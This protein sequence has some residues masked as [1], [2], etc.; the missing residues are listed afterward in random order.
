MSIEEQIA[1]LIQTHLQT[2]HEDDGGAVAR[3]AAAVAGLL[4]WQP[5]DAAPQDGTHFLAQAISAKAEFVI[6]AWRQGDAYRTAL[7][8]IG[9]THSVV[10]TQWAPLVRPAA[11]P[12]PVQ[13]ASASVNDR[14]SGALDPLKEKIS[15]A[16]ENVVTSNRNLLREHVGT[17]AIALLRDDDLVVK[18]AEHM[19]PALPFALRIVVKEDAF[20]AFLLKHRELLTAALQRA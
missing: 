12:A 19:Y 7:D 11:V 20:T 13:A 18:V 5:I 4:A 9:V 6:E 8:T 10:L 14:W 2:S 15:A 1:G 3:A 16:V 17:K